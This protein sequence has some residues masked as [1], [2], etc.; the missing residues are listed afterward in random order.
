VIPDAIPHGTFDFQPPEVFSSLHYDAYQCDLWGTALILFYLLTSELLY[1]FP[2]VDDL[3][4]QFFILARGMDGIEND[5]FTECFKHAKRVE[6]EE[7][8][9]EDE[10]ACHCHMDRIC[11]ARRLRPVFGIV[12]SL[13]FERR[14][15]LSNLLRFDADE[16]WDLDAVRRSILVNNE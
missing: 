7:Y 5:L 8:D 16:R 15:I 3:M 9:N 11:Q 13:S 1:D 12:E 6:Q 2:H 14:K 4:F 10:Q